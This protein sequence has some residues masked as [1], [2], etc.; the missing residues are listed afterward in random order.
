MAD[1]YCDDPAKS[2]LQP[3][4]I[5]ISVSP[6]RTWCSIGHAGRLSMVR[7]RGRMSRCPWRNGGRPFRSSAIAPGRE[8]AA[9]RSSAVRVHAARVGTGFRRGARRRRSRL[10]EERNP[11]G[12]GFAGKRTGVAKKGRP[13]PNLEDPSAAPLQAI[14]TARQPRLFS[15]P[16]RRHGCRGVRSRALMTRP[17]KVRA[18]LISPTTSIL[19]SCPALPPDFMFNRVSRG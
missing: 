16:C 19:D 9:H 1:E 2:S 18:H 6:V 5:C 11:I 12:C 7:R 15:R 14:G 8:G 4:P 3:P 10:A 13:F 17:G